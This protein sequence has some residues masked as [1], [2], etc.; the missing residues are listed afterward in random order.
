MTDLPSA[1]QINDIKAATKPHVYV[2]TIA[3]VVRISR[4]ALRAGIDPAGYFTNFTAIWVDEGHYEPAPTWSDAIRALKRPTILM[5]ATPYRNDEKFFHIQADARYRFT[6]HDAVSARLIRTPQ[7]TQVRDASPEGFV[8]QLI[9]TID[10]LPAGSRAIVRCANADSIRRCVRALE[11]ARRT[12]I[13]VH[14]TF[15]TTAKEP[16]FRKTVP[17][18]DDEPAQ[19]W[20]HQYKLV[21]GIDDPRFRVVAFFDDLGNDR[22]LVQQIGRVLRNPAQDPKDM[23]AQVLARTVQVEETWTKYMA[24][25]SEAEPAS[26]AAAPD[27]VTSILKHHPETIYYDRR[28]RTLISRDDTT[29]W[30]GFTY[31]LTARI[32][33]IERDT[34]LGD[35]AEAV[36]KEW[37]AADR[38]LFVRQAPDEFTVVLPY[39]SVRNS[40]YLRSMAFPEPRFGYT[41]MRRSGS[42]LFYLDTEG[43]VAEAVDVYLPETRQKLARLMA[44]N[45]RFT[46]VSLSNTDVGRRAIRARTLRAASIGDIAPDLTD[47][48]YLCSTA[49]GYPAGEPT[50]RR[51]VGM[52]RAR[53]RDSASEEETFSN[54]RSWTDRI[55]KVLEDEST[56]PPAVFGRYAEPV[57]QPDDPQ[58]RNILIDIDAEAFHREGD[59]GRHEL[60]LGDY[61]G[62][63]AADGSF[64]VQVGDDEVEAIIKWNEQRRRY[65]VESDS[66]KALGYQEKEGSQRELVT[67]INA[68]Q[69]FSIV[70]GTD[71]YIYSRSNFFRPQTPGQGAKWWLLDLLTGVPALDDLKTEKGKAID[72][73]GWQSSSVF[74]LID[75]LK[76][77]SKK[78]KDDPLSRHFP[79]IDFLL[80]ADMGTEVADFVACQPG[81]AAFIHA[82]AG[83]GSKRSASALQEVAS[84][85]TKNLL[86]L[87][88]LT[89]QTPPVDA[90]AAPWK[91]GHVKGTTNRLRLGTQTTSEAMWAR[92]RRELVDP[93]CEREVWLVVGAALSL[94]TLKAESKKDKP[95]D[96]LLQ[97][98]ALLQ[99]VWNAV[100]QCGARLRIFCSP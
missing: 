5:T 46:T 39:V 68:D 34:V 28:F 50:V 29:A 18:P 54:Y 47:H 1:A 48:A 95:S 100:S 98:H 22:A 38:T 73:D 52:G 15:S 71:H 60:L 51:Y 65:D 9:E 87:Q 57:D 84:Q 12:V 96:E 66:L 94:S 40:P 35:L 82:K 55:A 44:G 90:W 32:Y 83:S 20:V 42:H 77:P 97:I 41:L 80:C 79:E 58:P 6:H 7:F 99:T 85:A 16:N 89:Q 17:L 45:S 21:E 56:E 92:I 31:P 76:D 2:G 72:G 10:G 30:R 63:V 74:A 8:K 4:D 86:Y 75:T 62:T 53:I 27:L 59:D 24:F 43:Q 78:A 26:T 69:A 14:E 23:Q 11:D 36:E 3:K 81:R 49:S 93:N 33:R 70:P 61:A 67:A 19:F 64:T 37:D 13:G 91:S 88:P 25:D